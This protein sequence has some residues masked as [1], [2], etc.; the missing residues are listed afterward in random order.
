MLVACGI[1]VNSIAG[2]ETID[3]TSSGY[4][5]VGIHNVKSNVKKRKVKGKN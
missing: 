5:C 3:A 4:W 2:N 1:N